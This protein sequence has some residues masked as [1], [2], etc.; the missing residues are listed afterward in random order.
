MAGKILK[1]EKS[2]DIY[3]MRMNWQEFFGEKMEFH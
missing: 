2:G 1:P 3:L